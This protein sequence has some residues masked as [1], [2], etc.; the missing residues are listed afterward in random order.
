MYT[1]LKNDRYG[2]LLFFEGR[3]RSD[4]PFKNYMILKRR[5]VEEVAGVIRFTT[6][7]DKHPVKV[8][9]F[10]FNAVMDCDSNFVPQNDWHAKSVDAFQ[11]RILD[12]VVDATAN[13]LEYYY[14][15]FYAKHLNFSVEAKEVELFPSG[16][17]D[18]RDLNGK[19]LALYK[20]KHNN[21]GIVENRQSYAEELWSD[22][23]GTT[24][25]STI[26]TSNLSYQI[27]KHRY[28]VRSPIAHGLCRQPRVL[29][30][31]SRLQFEIRMAKWKNLLQ[32]HDEYRIC[33]A[34]KEKVEAEKYKWPFTEGIL[35][36]METTSHYF[37]DDCDCAER[38]EQ[39]GQENFKVELIQEGNNLTAVD[40]STINTVFDKTFV[41]ATTTFPAYYKNFQSHKVTIPV[42]KIRSMEV[43]KHGETK[44][45]ATF[46]KKNDTS[47]TSVSDSLNK[48]AV[49]FDHVLEA[50]YC[51][52]GKPEKPF[53]VKGGGA[54]IPFLSPKLVIINKPAGQR[55][56]EIELSDGPLPHM[57]ILSGMSYCRREGIG[58]EICSTKTTMHEPGFEIE[59]LTIFVNNKEAF[60][61][62]WFTPLDHYINYS[63]HIGRYHNKAI[64]GSVD[65]WK[66][67]NENWCVP[68]RFDD[69]SDRRGLVTAR[70]TFRKELES[71]WDAFV[72]RIPVE[73]LILDR[74]KN[75]K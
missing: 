16:T 54:R 40:A 47:M 41:E 2:S 31:G 6:P 49:F 11:V 27:L 23:P 26:M 32:Q 51:D 65:F 24:K 29:P 43:E 30:S 70:I 46:W 48:K 12:N 18:S 66:F 59:E 75:R 1:N 7:E 38:F 4:D 10:M 74:T 57:V 68:L 39:Y 42:I 52:P 36:E 3:N 15:S 72:T 53:P 22:A 58:T 37:V 35:T 13:P 63:K 33:R 61:S 34:D 73:D 8:S 21:K 67:Q 20:L 17:Y 44:T 9:R 19:E 62:P 45:M 60:R 28:R 55:S 50:V 64:G 71:S 56:Y 5:G 69:R 25:L 14:A